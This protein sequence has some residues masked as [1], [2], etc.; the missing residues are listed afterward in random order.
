MNRPGGLDRQVAQRAAQWY[1]R[2]QED[3]VADSERQA[4]LAWR[5]AH[6]AHEHAWQR[7]CQIM[8][9]MAR[10]PSQLGMKALDREQR[11]DR[12]AAIKTLAGLMVLAPVG[13]LAS[14]SDVWRQWSADYRTG[15]GERRRVTLSDGSVL[16]INTDS[17][18]DVRFDG[19]QRLLVLH[20][21][22]IQL[23]SG[24]DAGRPGAFRPLRVG[25]RDGLLEALGTRFLV[26]QLGDESTRVAVFE[27]AVA[28]SPVA[29]PGSR[30]VVSAGASTCLDMT[31]V[32]ALRDVRPHE[33]SWTRGMLVVDDQPLGKVIAE[34]GRYRR[35]WLRCDPAV[36]ALRLT[37]TFQLDDTDAALV[38]LPEALPVAVHYRT[39]FWVTVAPR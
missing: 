32:H 22:E 27:G 35:G 1:L 33:T 16:D 11:M 7:A 12:R 9:R 29:S 31:G 17:S 3:D 26:R 13:Y 25:T 24:K 18:V 39:P 10:I 20:H 6:P 2:L 34:L 37:A 21:G 30:A 38:A 15:T 8:D 28:A 5:E 4:C 14:H 19:R 23:I 36:Q